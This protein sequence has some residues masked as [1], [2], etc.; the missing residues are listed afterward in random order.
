MWTRNGLRARAPRQERCNEPVAVL[1][2][3]ADRKADPAVTDDWTAVDHRQGVLEA[4]VRSF[5]STVNM[6]SVVLL[7]VTVGIIAYTCLAALSSGGRNEQA[8]GAFDSNPGRMLAGRLVGIGVLDVVPG[9]L[10]EEQPTG[11]PHDVPGSPAIGGEGAPPATLA[12]RRKDLQARLDSAR[13]LIDRDA[14][15]VTMRGEGVCMTSCQQARAFLADRVGVVELFARLERGG[16]GRNLGGEPGRLADPLPGAVFAGGLGWA[17]RPADGVMRYHDGVDLT[18]PLGTEVVAADTGTVV[19][20]GT[21]GGYGLCVEIEH[22][23]GNHTLYA[24]LSRIDVA[25][26][27]SVARR[28]TIGVV[29]ATGLAG[30]PHLHFEYRDQRGFR[31]NPLAFF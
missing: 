8:P 3:D 23:D 9:L 28:Q 20:S 26:G 17:V 14:G 2:F 16:W 5:T 24:H 1:L 12:A 29:G 30:S 6:V 4:F 18:M 19:R 27:D 21:R 7:S 11:V 10:K 22:P 13:A 25:T 15:R 31:L